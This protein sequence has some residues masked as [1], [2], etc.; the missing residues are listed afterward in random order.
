VHRQ[1]TSQG[2]ER[3]QSL[4]TAAEELF[5][6]NGYDATR[7]TDICDAAGVTKSLFYWYFP[8]K[9]DLYVELVRALRHELRVTQAKA[10]TSGDDPL[11]QIR[12]GTEASVRFMAQHASYYARL[13]SAPVDEAIAAAATEGGDIYHGDVV[14]L[15]V[16]GQRAGLIVADDPSLLAIGVVTAVSS[17][18]DALRAGRVDRD[19]DSLADF[20][21]RLVV[22]SLARTP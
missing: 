11:E 20:V 6:R 15:V 3:K 4:L 16:A 8:T 21:G 7:V 2:E 1:H 22:R 14:S 18:S 19:I 10:M 9:R 13:H 17:F 5:A 12:L